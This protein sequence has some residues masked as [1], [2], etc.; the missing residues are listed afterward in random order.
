MSAP[1]LR[2]ESA[3]L[4][5]IDA[6]KHYSGVH[7]LRGASMDLQPGEVHG[8][9]GPNGAGKSTLV[10]MIAGVEELSGGSLTVDGHAVSLS[11]PAAAHQH[12]IVL[13]PQEISLMLDGTVAQNVVLGAEPT[14]GLILDRQAARRRAVDALKAIGLDVSPDA[15]VTGLSTVHRRLLMLARAIDRDPRLLIL[16]EPTA[17]LAAAEAEL[18]IETVS[19]VVARGVTIIY[20][21]HHLSEV[22][23]LCDRVTGVREGR[24]VTT[25]DR[26]EISKSA[27]VGLVVGDGESDHQRAPSVR[28]ADWDAVGLRLEGVSAERLRNVSLAAPVGCITGVTGLLGSGVTELVGVIAGAVQPDAGSVTLDGVSVALRSPADALDHGIG[29]LPGDRTTAAM[30]EMNVREN[31]T[32]SALQRWAKLGVV[33]ARRERRATAGILGDLEVAASQNLKITALSG[34]NQQR[35]LVGRLIA[36][37]VKVILLDEPTV[38]VDVAARLALWNVIE[39]LARTCV[40][41]VASSEPEELAAL[42]DQV[43]VVKD[44]TVSDRLVGSDLTI[45]GIT[46]SMT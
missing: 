5:V 27:L 20:I 16:D 32:L 42:C 41:I 35:A 38:G 33:S 6:S 21:S 17:G 26:H 29:Y 46:H 13:M 23:R 34:G 8:I 2:D 28:S 9:V 3:W 44:G 36:S 11:G 10:K 19:R 40:V 15:P 30:P 22:A 1:D 25:L 12:R 31:V 37:G 7:A 4:Q 18:V 43:F 45:E 14:R 39:D 24:V